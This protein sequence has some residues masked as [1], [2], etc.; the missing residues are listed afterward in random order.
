MNRRI[1]ASLIL[2]ASWGTLALGAQTK[3]QIPERAEERIRRE[4][5]HQILMLPYYDVFDN[6]TFKVEGYKVSLAGQVTRPT[7][8]SD[9]A[10]VVKRIEG[11]ERVD[12]QI[13]VLPVSTMDNQ[14]RLALYRAIYEYPALQRYALPV[15][16]PIRIVVKN[17]RVTLEGVVDNEADKNMITMRAN[18]VSGVFSVTNN[19]VVTKSK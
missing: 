9:A 3:R 15:I 18:G 17:G 14:L 5:R 13:E 1:L 4:V 19:L 12:N 8:K 7:L 16:K 6:I 10:N 11:V 2:L